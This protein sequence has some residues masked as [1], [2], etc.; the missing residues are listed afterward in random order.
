MFTIPNGYK[1]RHRIEFYVKE[2]ELQSIEE[3][4]D[5]NLDE[6]TQKAEE[7]KHLEEEEQKLGDTILEAVKGDE[8]QKD[9]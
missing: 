4:T 3:S 2:E 8:E 9:E 6:V 5:E 1:V 7:M